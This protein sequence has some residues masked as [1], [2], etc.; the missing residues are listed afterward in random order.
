MQLTVKT[1][2][3]AC[4]GG[5]NQSPYFLIPST[6][7]SGLLDTAPVQIDIIRTKRFLHVGDV[8]F[9]W[10][11]F[12]LGSQCG[13]GPLFQGVADSYLQSIFGWCI[14]RYATIGWVGL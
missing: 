1:P 11:A 10:R 6:I 12:L 3:S 2:S 4:K 14:S 8:Q 9:A 7:Q 13:G 5:S